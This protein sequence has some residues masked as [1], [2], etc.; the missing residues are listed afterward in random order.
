MNELH[1][2]I[3]NFINMFYEGNKNKFLREYSSFL[4]KEINLTKPSAGIVKFIKLKWG[5]S[6]DVLLGLE[7]IKLGLKNKKFKNLKKNSNAYAFASALLKFIQFLIEKKQLVANELDFR[8][9]IQ[10]P[11]EDA[12][13]FIDFY[14]LN[15]SSVNNFEILKNILEDRDIYI[16]AFPLDTDLQEGVIYIQSPSFIILN[17]NIKC[18]KSGFALAHEIGHLLYKDIEDENLEEKFANQFA[19]YLVIPSKIVPYVEE[20]FF[21]AKKE[22]NKIFSF[23]K[24]ICKQFNCSIHPN[25]AIERLYLEGIL[26]R[27]ERDFWRSEILKLEKN[28]DKRKSKS[29]W[30]NKYKEK[31]GIII[32]DKYKKAVE[33]LV[34]LDEISEKRAFELLFKGI[35]GEN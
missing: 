9:R 24:S 28:I 30:E 6:S 20:I 15:K 32:S 23:I 25:S 21:S 1:P 11:K 16:F 12:E 19:T 8:S 2:I 26:S 7:E 22:K 14:G 4:N 5:L 3:E 29:A 33:R 34:E 13:R 17:S 27:T 31:L 18:I 10:N 35:K